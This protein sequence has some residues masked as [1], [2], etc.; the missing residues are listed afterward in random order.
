MSGEARAFQELARRALSGKD[1]HTATGD[2]FSGL[3][4]KAAG[5][6]PRG[7]PHTAYQLLWHMSYW[8]DWVV[9]WL[10]GETPTSPQHASGSWPAEAG[11]ANRRDWEKAVRGFRRGLRKLERGCREADLSPWQN[12]KSRLAMLHAIAA[13]NSYHAGEVAFL[14]QILGT[15]PPPSG[16]LT[17]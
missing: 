15:W 12:R 1:A 14:R 9:T 3:G 16:G 17:W 6:K 8:Q 7:A 4:W 2:V 11:P 13:H 5:K 10:E